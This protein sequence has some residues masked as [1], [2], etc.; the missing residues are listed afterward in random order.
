MRIVTINPAN[1][2]PLQSYETLSPSALDATLDRAISAG[3]TWSR[4]SIAERAAGLSRLG[5]VLRE[6]RDRLA[7]LAT[8]E[9]GK[10][11]AEAKAEIDKCALTCD[12]YAEH[13][14]AF[15][16][17]EEVRTEARAAYVELQPLGVLL[18]IMPWN[19]PY[20]Q[21]IRAA[22]P[23]LAAGNAIVIKHADN[24]TGSN[25][26]LCEAIEAAGLT[27]GLVS[28]LVLE[29]ERVAGV[30]ADHRIAAVTLTGSTRAGRAVAAAAGA[31]LKKTVLELGGSDAFIVLADA[32]LDAAA[33]WAVRSRF[34]NAGQ[35]C[36]AAKRLIV[37]QSVADTFIERV[38]A[39]VRT[40]RLGDP[41]DPATTIGPIARRDLHVQLAA[42][43]SAS[44]ARGAVAL[45]GGAARPGPGFF[46]EPTVLDRV[47]PDMPVLD[48]EVFGPALPVIRVRDA[49]EAVEVANR[50]AYGLGSALW[51]ADL[52]RGRA[53]ASRLAAGHSVVNGMTASDPRL[54]FGGIKQSGYGREL[55]H[56]GL[57]EFVNVHAVVVN[58]PSGP[59]ASPVHKGE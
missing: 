9:M 30:I 44:L 31:V 38:C 40:L 43:V 18:A 15:L 14:E 39:E 48:E 7:S 6:R 49:D 50:S 29:V 55:S 3:K 41:V 36:I 45:V 1:G 59:P 8:A 11:I 16:R 21:A 54:P 28:P 17:A 22:A 10:T 24:T 2:K 56:H 58:D 19:F 27:Y 23:A 47:T 37:E 20:W 42:Q 57:R 12:F 53:L 52:A 26:A 25:L 33:R 5:A 13:A 32:D 51:T 46:Y 35:S 4:L 34:Q